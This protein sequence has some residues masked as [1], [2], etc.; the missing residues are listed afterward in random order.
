MEV[1]RGF[2]LQRRL[3]SPSGN[4]TLQSG[5]FILF[6]SFFLSFSFQFSPL[7]Q[8][9]IITQVRLR[10]PPFILSL[11]LSAFSYLGVYQQAHWLY[12]PLCLFALPFLLG[13]TLM[14]FMCHW[15]SGCLFFFFFNSR[16]CKFKPQRLVFC[17]IGW[18]IGS[19]YMS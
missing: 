10:G 7:N 11:S 4:S 9:T 14:C 17:E 12:Y 8:S 5:P 3:F 18:W 15:N 19:I 13:Y 6:L 16:Q 1:G 2:G